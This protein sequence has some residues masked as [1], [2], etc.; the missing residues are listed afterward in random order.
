VADFLTTLSRRVV[1]APL[2]DMGRTH[3]VT[4]R[5][6]TAILVGI[7][8]DNDQLPNEA[9]LARQL[10]VSPVTLR[11]A[12]RALREE[13]LLRT[14]RGRSGGTFVTSAPVNARTFLRRLLL[15]KSPIELRDIIDLQTALMSHAARLAADRGT[16]REI[17]SLF[18]SIETMNRNLE[19][20][21]LR[22]TFSRY[23]IGVA[24]ASRSGQLSRTT[25]ELQ[26][27]WA[28]LVTLVFDSEK[29]RQEIVANTSETVRHLQ[30]RDAVAAFESMYHL[31]ENIGEQLLSLQFELV[32]AQ[33]LGKG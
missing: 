1:L 24:S 32:Q 10:A 15:E 16:D 6:R 21:L 27:E 18:R 3:E 29:C 7:F 2:D 30:S 26:V 14:V 13:G 22:R 17:A 12:I 19:A 23:L 4:N 28:P 25:I 31:L 33:E 20:T 9:S 5:I 11:E 8:A